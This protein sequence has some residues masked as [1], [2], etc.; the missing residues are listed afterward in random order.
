MR[1]LVTI[2][3]GRGGHD[4]S[5]PS[6]TYRG[7]RRRLRDIRLRG[8]G[9]VELWLLVAWVAFLLFIVVPWMIRQGR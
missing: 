2:K 4:G 1:S 6:K 7:S 9:S 5:R 3:S 8:N